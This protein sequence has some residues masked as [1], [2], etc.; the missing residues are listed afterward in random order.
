MA[1]LPENDRLTGPMTAVA[2][3][4]AFDGDFPLIDAPNDPVGT[5]VFM[6]RVRAGVTTD[7]TLGAFT[8]SAVAANAFTLSLVTPALAGDVYWIVGR[9]KQKRLR[10]HPE[11]GA[12][13]TPTLEDDAREAA[14]RGQEARRDLDRTVMS[15]LGEAGL[16]LPTVAQR[17]GRLAAFLTGGKFDPAGRTLAAF[18]ADVAAT[19]AAAAAAIQAAAVALGGTISAVLMASTAGASLVGFIM[20]G[21][22][23]VQE[24]LQTVIRRFGGYPQSYGAVA[25]MVMA[26]DGA[27]TSGSAVFTSASANFIAGDAGKTIKVSGAGA[28]GVPLVTTILSRNS[29]T[30]V[31][32]ATS[33]STTVSGTLYF[34]GSD[35]TLAVQQAMLANRRV[36]IDGSHLIVGTLPFRTGHH[37]TLSPHSAMVHTTALTPLFQ[38]TSVN[39]ITVEGNGASLWG[40]GQYG[41]NPGGSWTGNTSSEDRIF[42]FTNCENLRLADLYAL[43]AGHGGLVL[44]GCR[45]V[46]APNLRVEGTNKHS[47]PIQWPWV[48]PGSHAN[49]QNGVLLVHDPVYGPCDDITIANADLSG[50]AQGVLIEWE[51]GPPPQ[52]GISFPDAHIHDIPGQHAFYIQSGGINVSNPTLRRIALSGIKTQLGG[53][54]VTDIDGCTYLGVD[55]DYCGSQLFEFGVPLG[56]GMTRGIKAQGHGNRVGRLASLGTNI[57]N[58]DLDLT[59]ENIYGAAVQL[60]GPG[61]TDITAKVNAVNCGSSALAD[62]SNGADRVV[63]PEFIVCGVNNPILD[64]FIATAGQ[65][66][67]T[68]VRQPDTV[69][70]EGVSAA[71]TMGDGVF[72]LTTPASADDEVVAHYTVGNA[73]SHSGARINGSNNSDITFKHLDVSDPGGGMYAAVFLEG[74]GA[75]V[76]VQ[77]GRLRDGTDYAARVTSGRLTLP[78]NVLADMPYLGVERIFFDGDPKFRAT[79]DNDDNVFLRVGAPPAEGVFLVKAT[80]VGTKDDGSQYIGLTISRL[81]SFDGTTV[82][83]LD[84]ED[85]VIH[86]QSGTFDGT[87][88]LNAGTGGDTGVGTFNVKVTSPDPFTWT[89]QESLN[90]V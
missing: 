27:I 63:F 29:A 51:G 59:G 64:T 41:G 22:G 87:Y 50:T 60:S 71:F 9:Q 84:A 14:A 2:A 76:K 1:T 39:N 11:G 62:F 78:G 79:S 44:R 40:H 47:S 42:N 34:Y 73:A 82:L 35:D 53:G 8:V 86:G 19:A 7:L 13:R 74:G 28:G 26:R 43:D 80:I 6:R 88:S 45:K 70:R 83:A 20:S 48:A 30:S 37:L 10:A 57:Q 56:V 68:A 66:R 12:V 15:P 4:T 67:F 81:F 5:C 77:S 32:L 25:D 85:P 17:E 24:T 54:V 61:L 52:I 3:Q 46:R 69:T 38:G 65:T 36:R 49:F 58:V 55:G 16:E 72:I 23:A 90:V 75:D 89:L 21:V 18:D 33:A 31:T